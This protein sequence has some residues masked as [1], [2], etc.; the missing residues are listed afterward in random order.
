M[1]VKNYKNLFTLDVELLL[2]R[3][4]VVSMEQRLFSG[5]VPELAQ[6]TH[7]PLPPLL[8]KKVRKEKNVI[9]L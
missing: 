3:A 5:L 8:H 6:V 7:S 4:L 2:T 1:I 9:D